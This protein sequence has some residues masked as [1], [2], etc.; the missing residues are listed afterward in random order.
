[1][2]DEVVAY[3]TVPAAG[4]PDGALDALAQA[5]ALT[6]ASPSAVDAYLA[7]RTPGGHALPVPGAVVCVGPVTAEAARRAGLAVA[8]VAAEP[9]PAAFVEAVAAALGA[10]GP[11]GLG[12]GPAS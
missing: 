5:D 9:T 7:L 6:L 3:R 4:P 1:V 11:A 8:A 10:G 12:A 2:V